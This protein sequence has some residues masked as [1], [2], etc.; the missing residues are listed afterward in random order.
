MT[1]RRGFGSVRRLPSGR[2]QAR[3][4][5]ADGGMVPA[6]DTF[7]TKRD[8]DDWLATVQAD[9]SRGT[10]LDPRRSGVTLAAYA[11]GWLSSR[12]VKGRPLA[13]RT[14]ET[15]RHSLDAWILPT[16]GRLELSQLTP[17]VVRR[18]HAEVS[19]A[20]GPTATRQAY[21]T[22]RAIL[23]TAVDDE[24]LAR[25]PCRIRG[26]G[27]SNSPERPLL[28]REQV[29]ALAGAMP[30]YL[31][32]LVLVTF[33]GHLRLGE[34][35]ALRRCNVDLDAGTVRVESQLVEVGAQQVE[36]AP[37]A[38]SVRTVHLADPGIEVLREHLAAR[39]PMMPTA[40]LFVRPDGRDLRAHHV[41][42]PWQTARGRLGLD[43]VHFHDLRHAGLTLA[44]QSGATLA[45]VMRR[46]GHASSRAALI[47]QHAAASRDAEIARRMGAS[48]NPTGTRLARGDRP[49]P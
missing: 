3:Y 42:G 27:Q 47:Y 23:A 10:W 5:T 29:A 14:V 6:P 25:N 37:K 16:L 40:R 44:A 2:W 4:G 48:A 17:A 30:E 36:T 13:P 32:A 33:W 38:A 28:D 43:G 11:Q 9:M 41:E 8:A 19:A 1:R 46:A 34:V 18:W 22:L 20:T 39:G 12:R 45:E 15:Y 49:A 31:R 24:A 21:G 35:L 26:A 7:P